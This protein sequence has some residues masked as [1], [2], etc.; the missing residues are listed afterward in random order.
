MPRRSRIAPVNVS[1]PT[2]IHGL[3][4]IGTIAVRRSASA[5]RGRSAHAFSAPSSQAGRSSAA[6]GEH[7]VEARERAVDGADV[8]DVHGQAGVAQRGQ[9]GGAVLLLVGDD[10]VGRQGDDRVDVGVLRAADPRRGSGARVVEAGGWVH[11]SV[12]PTSRPG[13]VTPIASVSEGTR[14]TTRRTRAGTGTAFPRSSRTVSRVVV[15]SAMPPMVPGTRALGGRVRPRH[16]V[17]CVPHTFE[18]ARMDRWA[19]GIDTAWLQL[20]QETNR[21]VVHGVLFCDRPVDIDTL[22]ARVQERWVDA[23]PGFRQRPT[24]PTGSLGL[25]RWVDAPPDLA[26]HVTTMALDDAGGRRDPGA[27]TRR[28]DVARRCPRTGRGGGSSCSPGTRAAR[29]STWPSTTGSPTASRSTTSS[30]SLADAVADPRTPAAYGRAAARRS[31][32]VHDLR[33]MGREVRDRASSLWATIKRSGTPEGASELVATGRAVTS[34]AMLLARPPREKPSPLQ[35]RPGVAEGG[36]LDLRRL[37][38]RGQGGGEGRGRQRQRRRL[39][40]DRRCAADLPRRR[41]R[42]PTARGHAHQPAPARPADLRRARQRVRARPAPAA[43][44]RAR[45][46]R[47]AS[48][49]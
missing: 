46:R 1:R 20:E 17:P 38:G 37:P 15:G 49:G 43:H 14:L 3:R 23:Y 42:A 8:G 44:R 26:A 48:S 13:S 11:Q 33:L 12:T 2:A 32:A 27:P 21:M 45:S 47:A 34:S 39:R 28:A 10:E 7:P 9:I 25:V 36:P 31:E 19:S 35:G 29:P 6:R 22:R 40:R 16:P 30:T 4:Q 24:W 41:R 18:G 5:T